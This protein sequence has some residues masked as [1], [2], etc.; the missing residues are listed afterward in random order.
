[1]YVFDNKSV[2]KIV[3]ALHYFLNVYGSKTCSVY[4]IGYRQ[5]KPK[6]VPNIYGCCAPHTFPK[7]IYIGKLS[8]KYMKYLLPINNFRKFQVPNI[9]RVGPFFR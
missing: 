2:K 4:K 9:C 6:E 3:Y 8:C 1:M 5:K 7:G